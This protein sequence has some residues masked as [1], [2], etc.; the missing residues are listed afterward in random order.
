MKTI[1]QAT[2]ARVHFGD[3]LQRVAER[4]E[5]IIVERAG[6]AKVAIVPIDEYEELERFRTERRWARANQLVQQAHDRIRQELGDRQLP[7]IEDVIHEMREERD[8]QLL[9]NLLGCQ[10]RHT[11]RD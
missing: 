1:M 5:T 9:G 10:P 6:T 11:T 4:H 7:P 8:A 3:V 2:E